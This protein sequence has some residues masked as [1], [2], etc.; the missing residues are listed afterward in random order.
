MM[1]PAPQTAPADLSPPSDCGVLAVQE[2]NLLGFTVWTEI[3]P[4][5]G[6]DAEPLLLHHRSLG[7]GLL[8]VLDGSGGSGSGNAWTDP[9]GVPHSGAWVGS[10]VARLGA[11]SWFATQFEG[12]VQSRPAGP[13]ELAERLRTALRI[14]P[15]SNRSKIQGDMLRRLPTTI[16]L[17]RYHPLPQ[18]LLWVQ[19]LWAGDSRGYCLRPDQGLQALTRDHTVETDALAQLTQDPPVTNVLCADQEFRVDRHSRQLALPAVLLCA[20]DGF[21]GYLQTPADFELLLLDTLA[22]AAGLQHWAELLAARV[23]QYTADDAS[24]SLVGL[25]YRDFAELRDSFAVRTADL[26][27]LLH[28]RPA[29]G[30]PEHL[31][32]RQRMWRLYRPTYEAMM[33]PVPTA[34]STR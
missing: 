33:P 30:R 2:P 21:F 31:D 11:E 22:G 24:L 18:D 16:A 8:G 34:G 1:P 26:D 20:T 3:N 4:G 9:R 12:A 14:L 17:I 5:H 28:R 15:D 7:A 32:W 27:E 13:D 29:Q 6:E 19:S 10:R 25:G 23:T